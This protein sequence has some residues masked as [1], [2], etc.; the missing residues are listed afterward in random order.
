[1]LT[2]KCAASAFKFGQHFLFHFDFW[3]LQ[4]MNTQNLIFFCFT[5]KIYR[6]KNLKFQYYKK[7]DYVVFQD[8]ASLT[9]YE[10]LSSRIIFLQHHNFIVGVIKKQTT[11]LFYKIFGLTSI[12]YVS[13]VFE[14][15]CS[16]NRKK[17]DFILLIIISPF[18]FFQTFPLISMF[19]EWISQNGMFT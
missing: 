8:I 15:V 3:L 14:F 2:I 19:D 10:F 1:M 4:R 16:R 7:C 12:C 9:S 6:M 11:P 13:E 5:K 17:K 18:L